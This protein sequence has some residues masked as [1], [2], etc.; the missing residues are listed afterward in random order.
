MP[1]HRQL[2][3]VLRDQIARGGLAPGAALPSEQALGKLYDVSR[4][5]VRRALQ[6]LSDDDYVVRRHGLGTYVAQGTVTPALPHP[7]SVKGALRQ[8]QLETTVEVMEVEQ[9]VVPARVAQALKLD[10]GSPATY[11]LRVRSNDRGPLMV[12]EA[13]VPLRFSGQVTNEA[14]RRH[15]LYE[16]VEQAG[17]VLGRVTQ[18]IT[19]AIADPVRARLLGVEIGSAL[20]RIIR[21]MHD[22]GGDPVQLVTIDVTPERSR[23][24]TEVAAEDIDTAATGILAHDVAGPLPSGQTDRRHQP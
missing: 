12:T 13:W 1:L 3:L 14:L 19:A 6:D 11:V 24:L 15:A 4:I 2:Y 16:L 17:V 9:R 7:Q 5:T 20:L 18:E 21:V 10:A 8:A 22:S 23:V